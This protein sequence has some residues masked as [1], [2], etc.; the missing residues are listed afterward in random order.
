MKGCH[1]CPHD[2]T[3]NPACLS[4]D[5]GQETYSYRYEQYLIDTYTPVQPDTSGSEKVTSLP[6]DL[7]D[8][9]RKVL[10]I[11]FD[12][13]PLELLVLQ[14]IM[15]GKSLTDFATETTRLFQYKSTRVMTRHHAFQLRKSVLMKL[16]ILKNALLTVGQ[17]KSLKNPKN[18]N[19]D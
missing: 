14:A 11:I 3:G 19:K 8:K 2:G 16:P 5:M 4:C 17:R 7:E 18:P 15:T 9:L 6:E 13:S 1:R 10:Y 12:L